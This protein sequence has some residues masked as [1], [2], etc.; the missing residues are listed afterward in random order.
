MPLY[1]NEK[2]IYIYIIKYIYL[3]INIDHY[4]YNYHFC[5]H[6]IYICMPLNI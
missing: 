6:Y 2:Y 3:I 1:I 4:I 5:C